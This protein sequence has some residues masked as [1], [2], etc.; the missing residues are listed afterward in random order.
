M[1][2]IIRVVVVLGIIW[3][4]SFSENGKEITSSLYKS[5]NLN[6]DISQYECSDVVD[7]IKG[8]ELQNA[9][10]ARFK[11]VFIEDVKLISQNN[12]KIICSGDLKLSNGTNQRMKLSV[13]KSSDNEIYYEISP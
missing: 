7:L 2:W 5:L 3:F 8:K 6:T 13:S 10:G 12:N 1:V 4:I 9:F 11:I